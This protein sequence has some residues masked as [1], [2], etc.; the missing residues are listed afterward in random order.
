MNNKL[1]VGNLA[2]STTE[3]AI[4]NVFA[5][6]GEVSEVK[7]MLD[8]ATGQSRGF[9]FVTMASE[10]AAQKA[11]SQ[12]SGSMLDGRPLRVDRAEERK[13]RYDGGGG[14]GG[15]GGRGKGRY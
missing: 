8:R 2:F 7:L 9:S 15:G 13:P 14:G 11:L 4:R 1:Y 5:E 6:F 12:L 10:D 3:D